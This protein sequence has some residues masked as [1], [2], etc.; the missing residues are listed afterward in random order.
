MRMT[1]KQHREY[2]EKRGV[3][4]AG[5]AV[6][7]MP[8]YH[9]YDSKTE[10]VFAKLGA[11]VLRAHLKE[12]ITVLEYHPWMFHLLGEDYNIDFLAITEKGQVVCVETK[13]SKKAKNYRDA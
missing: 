8:K 6:E 10:L 13:G 4:P 3:L 1:E 2:L 11:L 5:A 7:R 9:P 12:R